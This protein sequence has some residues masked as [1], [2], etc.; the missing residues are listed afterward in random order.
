MARGVEGHLAN[1]ALA[2]A[3]GAPAIQSLQRQPSRM[4]TTARPRK[5]SEL[6]QPLLWLPAYVSS[7]A[8]DS[9]PEETRPVA[10]AAH[11]PRPRNF[12][13][14]GRFHGS[15][16]F[17]CPR[18]IPCASSSAHQGTAEVCDEP[19]LQQQ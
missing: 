13:S 15:P 8:C 7:M 5:P 18:A 10:A 17:P 19:A 3:T 4:P 6:G 11:E 2:T 14:L 12:G 16:I 9:R 1:L